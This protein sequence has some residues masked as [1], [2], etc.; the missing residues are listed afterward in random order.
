MTEI[1]SDNPILNSPYEEPTF[2]YATI[3]TGVEKGS[4]D[5][6]RVVKGRRVFAS[7]SGVQAMPSRKKS[8]QTL[9]YEDV[10]DFAEDYGL[11]LVNLCR[12]EVG[13]WRKANYPNTTRVT[14]ELLYYWFLNEDRHA[15]KQLFFAQREAV[16]TAIWLNEV[17]EK[18]NAG[19]NILNVLRDGQLDV[20]ENPEEQL[21]RIAF[22]MATGTGK[23]VVMACF[24]LYHFFNRQE[25]RNDTRFADYF[26]VVAPGITIRDRLG[27]LFVDTKHKNASEVQD[28]YHI[29]GLVPA[30]L[31]DKL[32]NLNAKLVITNYRSFEPKIIKGNKR[33]PFDG[34][35]D[36]EGNKLDT[37]NTED[38]A[39]VAR[40]VLSKFKTGSRLLI[41]NDE[42][43]HCYLPKSKGKTS[44][45]EDVDENQRAAVWFSG[46]KELM[47]KSCG[48]W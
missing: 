15:T 36:L 23:T 34:K 40:R 29:R 32:V 18:S 21:P 17:A 41:L 24:I 20:S 26:L 7:D 30:K 25:Y 33:S 45:N 44:D 46:I 3:P 9:L 5:Y 19:Q 22:K 27:V 2:H 6:T 42:A 37:N 38:F 13:I 8:S 48:K 11:Q 39:Q 43:H 28:Y 47:L 12:K 35:V 4:L 31:E 10:N 14:K 16:E 1:K